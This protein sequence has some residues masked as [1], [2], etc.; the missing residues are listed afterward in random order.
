MKPYS[1]LIEIRDRKKI[2]EAAALKPFGTMPENGSSD[3]K[4]S[5]AVGNRK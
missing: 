4:K 3:A 2:F 1:P 5:E